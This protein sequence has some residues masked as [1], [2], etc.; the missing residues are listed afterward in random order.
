LT[1][2]V[3]PSAKWPVVNWDFLQCRRTFATVVVP[4]FNEEASLRAILTAVRVSIQKRSFSLTTAV[5]IAH[6]Q[7]WRVAEEH[8]DDA[9]NHQTLYHDRNRGK[10]GTAY[11]FEH[12]SGDIILF[13]IGWNTTRL[14]FSYFSRFSRRSRRRFGSRFLGDRPTGYSI[15]ALPR[16]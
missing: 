13:K 14:I 3:V 15:L 10:G 2:S 4:V 5:A 16:Q 1:P 12:A 8:A 6:G 9:D 7:L 11:R